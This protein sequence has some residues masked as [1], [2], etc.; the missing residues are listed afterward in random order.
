MDRAR[1]RASP[2]ASAATSSAT[3][4]CLRANAAPASSN[5]DCGWITAA[6]HARS[7]IG[8]KP[9][10]RAPSSV[11]NFTAPGPS[12]PTSA[13]ITLVSP[14]EGIDSTLYVSIGSIARMRSA[15]M[16]PTLW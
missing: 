1:H 12:L 6:F 13:S 7:R 16:G 8:A 14:S 10:T 2:P 11:S 3:A 4:A 9:A 5:C 15:G